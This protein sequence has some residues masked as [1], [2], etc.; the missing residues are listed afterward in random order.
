MNCSFFQ[1][2]SLYIICSDSWPSWWP[3]VDLLQSVNVC[4]VLG[5]PELDTGPQ[6]Q[7]CKCQIEG[8]NHS[9]GRASYACT[10]TTLD[11]VGPLC[12]KDTLLIH[13]WLAVHEDPEIFFCRTASLTVR[14]SLYC[15]MGLFCPRSKT[16]FSP[17]ALH[18]VP[19]AHF[20]RSLWKVAF[21]SSELTTPPNLVSSTNLLREVTVLSS[22]SLMKTLNHLCAS[23]DPWGMPLVTGHQLSSQFQPTALSTYPVHISPVW[24]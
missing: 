14:P 20:S 16:E 10:N 8:K 23:L 6:M 5:T 12:C 15:C 4:F 24:W 17:V 22:W 2:L 19:V 9:T 3:P 11:A 7:F 13:V 18:Q 1:S 21:P